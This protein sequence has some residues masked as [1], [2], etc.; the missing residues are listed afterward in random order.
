MYKLFTAAV[1]TTITK[2]AGTTKVSEHDN[3]TIQ[4][5]LS[6]S[7]SDKSIHPRNNA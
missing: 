1:D 5:I 3:P 6:Q 2:L 4:D 7:E